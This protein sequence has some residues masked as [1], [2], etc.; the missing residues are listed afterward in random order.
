VR[1]QH[2]PPPALHEYRRLFDAPVEF[3][4]EVTEIE[5]D[6]E[7]LTRPVVG[8][9]A[10]LFSV[11]RSYAESELDIA[12]PT[13]DIVAS[14]RRAIA[15]MLAHEAPTVTIVSRRLG[16][17]PRTLNRRLL[18]QGTTFR[19]IVTDVRSQLALAYLKNPVLSLSDVASLLGFAEQS[20]FHRAFKRW[21]GMSPGEYR[22][23]AAQPSI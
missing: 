14:V 8:A 17:S 7:L 5:F 6:A 2:A 12:A 18:A 15:R 11:L 21:S 3:R 4:C 23:L 19:G 1:F 20:S 9:D 22:T 16:M 10:R 13:M